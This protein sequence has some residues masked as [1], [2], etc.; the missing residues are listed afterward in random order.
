MARILVAYASKMGGTRELAG[1]FAA[2]LERRG[3]HI[4]LRAADEVDDR[5]AYE[6]AVIGSAIYNG[7]WRPE[8]VALLRRMVR[9]NVA[10]PVWIFHSGPLGADAKD[11]QPLPSKVE[12]LADMLDTRAVYTFGGRL[13]SDPPGFVA[14]LLARAQAG[15]W[16]DFDAVIDRAHHI[17]DTLERLEAAHQL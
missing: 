2:T 1:R 14:K 12:A 16:R 8:A 3:H 5:M 9:S 10:L 15:D 7:R 13:P 4:D 17:A 6:A 11:P